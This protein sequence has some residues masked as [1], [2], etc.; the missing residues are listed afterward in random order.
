MG[1]IYANLGANFG[2]ESNIVQII[3]ATLRISPSEIADV[4]VLKKGMTNRSFSFRC[5]D[6]RYLMRIPGEGANKL[7]NRKQECAVYERIQN[8]GICDDIEYINAENGYKITRFIENARVCDPL[9]FKDVARCVKR[10]AR[11]P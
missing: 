1:N 4:A 5:G 9:N 8:L 10:S 2:L 7:I 11:F 6:K 3:T